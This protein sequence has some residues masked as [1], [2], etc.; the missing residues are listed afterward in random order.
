[1]KFQVVLISYVV[2]LAFVVLLSYVVLISSSAM[3]R[4]FVANT[5]TR[6]TL[7]ARIGM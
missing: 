7:G 6:Y 1:L 2:H 5:G 4:N 3:N